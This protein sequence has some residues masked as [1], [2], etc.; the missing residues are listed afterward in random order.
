[1]K[2]K[3]KSSTG[4]KFSP[5][6]AS[7]GRLFG[8]TGGY[9]MTAMIHPLK[10]KWGISDAEKLRRAQVD[11]DISGPVY[12]VFSRVIMFGW[13]CEQFVHFIYHFQNAPLEKGTGRTEWFYNFNPIFGGLCFW[14][15]WNYGLV[16]HERF[17]ITLKTIWMC[18]IPAFIFPYIWI[19]GLIWLLAFRLLGWAAAAGMAWG[20]WKL[21]I[22]A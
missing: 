10:S 21:Y 11:K 19:D 22:S 15:T 7:Q 6:H 17:D 14:I 5:S 3:K 2:R 8:E 20:T 16:I 13:T 9:L 12:T 1:M 18:N 4:F